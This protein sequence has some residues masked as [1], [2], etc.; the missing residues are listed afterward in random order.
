[1]THPKM[2][3]SSSDGHASILNVC[4][5]QSDQ[6]ENSL[7]TQTY[8]NLQLNKEGMLYQG[9]ARLDKNQG[10]ISIPGNELEV[11]FGTKSS[12]QLF[13]FRRNTAVIRRHTREREK[14]C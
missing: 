1:M 13:A 4:I 9:S 3:L 8:N 11:T 6:P 14:S 5:T 2:I 10:C 7:N 12:E